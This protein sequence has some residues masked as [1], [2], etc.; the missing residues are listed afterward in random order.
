MSEDNEHDD[1]RNGESTATDL[2]DDDNNDEGKLDL[3]AA[4]KPGSLLD[5]VRD[6]P[7][8]SQPGSPKRESA[9]MVSGQRHRRWLPWLIVIMLIGSTIAV[10]AVVG[11]VNRS[12]WSIH[13]TTTTIVAQRGRAFPPWGFT[14]IDDPD[15]RAIQLANDTECPSKATDSRKTLE[16]WFV[17]AL[18]EQATAHLHRRR[19]NDVSTAATQL[20]Q[21]LLLTRPA[22]RQDL[23]K[24]VE[25]LLGDVEYWGAS[26]QLQSYAE[27]LLE[28]AQQFD[29]AAL[30]RPRH[31]SDASSWAIHVRSLVEQLKAGPSAKNAT[32]SDDAKLLSPEQ[33]GSD[34]DKANSNVSG[35]DTDRAP[36]SSEPAS[37]VLL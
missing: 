17:A 20:Q 8:P 6:H 4:S 27:K 12:H 33:P 22:A 34:N 30:K 36:R 10:F 32:E 15:L 11:S 13:C 1:N 23:R 16:D 7:L 9:A 31:V 26:G 3:R 2:R 14:S 37:G 24:E 19:D 28:T 25:R 21:A 35:V 29:Q 18:M 5:A